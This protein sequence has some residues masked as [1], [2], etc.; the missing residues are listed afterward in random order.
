MP[1]KQKNKKTHLHHPTKFDFF[2]LSCTRNCWYLITM[3][4]S[5]ASFSSSKS[6]ILYLTF[7]IWFSL[8]FDS[9]KHVMLRPPR[10]LPPSDQSIHYEEEDL[11][12]EI[13]ILILDTLLNSKKGK[14][15]LNDCFFYL[16]DVVCI[17]KDQKIIFACFRKGF[18]ENLCVSETWKKKNW[19]G[20]TSREF[21]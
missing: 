7:R 2:I 20:R 15:I 9:R 13:G 16:G 8:C 12:Q 3:D 1:K 11:R 4:I 5:T 18:L 6:H 19:E 14:R 21:T 10:H 17:R